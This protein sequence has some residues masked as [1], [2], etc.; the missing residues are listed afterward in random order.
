[1]YILIPIPVGVSRVATVRGAVWKVVSCSHCNDRYA[2][3]LELEATGADHD[4]LFVDG[5]D[6]AKRARARAEENLSKMSRN[7]VLP[8]PCPNCGHYQDDMVRLLKEEGTSNGPVKAGLIVA[9]LSLIP[10]AFR[11]PYLWIVTV[12]GVLAGLALV[13]YADVAASR[14]NPNAGDPEPRKARGRRR[15][16]WGEELTELLATSP[17]GEPSAPADRPRE[18]GSS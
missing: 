11:V 7:V 13:A 16:V 15:A 14:F 2:Y 6:S 1:V 12:A 8:V 17:S 5:E 10:L 18:H 9:A 3:L 4:L